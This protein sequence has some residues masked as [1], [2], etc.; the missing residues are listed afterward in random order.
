MSSF[1]PFDGYAHL[2]CWILLKFSDR[3]TTMIPFASLPCTTSVIIV[4]FPTTIP[5][6]PTYTR[7]RTSMFFAGTPAVLFGIHIIW[8]CGHK[9]NHK[10]KC[11]DTEF[12]FKYLKWI[13]KILILSQML[14]HLKKK[15]IGNITCNKCLTLP[16][17]QTKWIVSKNL[18]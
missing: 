8:N 18:K 15:E 13:I 11:E 17:Y 12:H 6:L 14:G 10:E 16:I 9:N 1:W 3:D 7:T 5:I 2:L 4:S